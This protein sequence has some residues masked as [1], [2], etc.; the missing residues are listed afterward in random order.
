MTKI[1]RLFPIFGII[2]AVVYAYVLY[3][4]A[5]L[6]TYHPMLGEWDFGRAASRK[7]PAMYWYGLV[8]T[9][10]VV[11]VPLTALCALVP[12]KFVDKAW[13]GF[14]WLVPLVAMFSFVWLLWPYFTKQ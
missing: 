10:F 3:H 11:A 5:P 2:F 6:A 4:D 12:Q 1:G 9:A 7:G 8:L 14:A 13:S